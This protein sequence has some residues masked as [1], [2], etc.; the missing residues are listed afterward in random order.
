MIPLSY[1]FYIPINHIYT[2]L[3]DNGFALNT[4]PKIRN[5]LQVTKQS[6]MNRTI[7]TYG[8]TQVLTAAIRK[9]KHKQN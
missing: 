9:K 4:I 6:T 2:Y 1:N 8:M 7:K 3:K 5:L